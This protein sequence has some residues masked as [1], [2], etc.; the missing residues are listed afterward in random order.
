MLWTIQFDKWLASSRIR[1]S[2]ADAWDEKA[3]KDPLQKRNTK[4]S[5]SY[6]VVVEDGGVLRA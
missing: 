3:W 5:M 1:K 6:Y 4:G 2:K